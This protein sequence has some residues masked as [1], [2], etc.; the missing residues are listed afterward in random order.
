MS[1]KD[2]FFWTCKFILNFILKFSFISITT[3]EKAL[4]SKIMKDITKGK[5]F[6]CAY[7]GCYILENKETLNEFQVLQTAVFNFELGGTILLLKKIPFIIT[8]TKLKLLDFRQWGYL[9]ITYK[10]NVNGN[11]WSLEN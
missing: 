8:K 7:M 11:Q 10:M 9:I 2:F 1:I 4:L 5:S 6:Q 3:S